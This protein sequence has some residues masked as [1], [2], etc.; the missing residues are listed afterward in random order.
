ME[1]N[2]NIPE[3]LVKMFRNILLSKSHIT[4]RQEISIEEFNRHD[5]IYDEIK[6]R[7]AKDITSHILKEIDKI[8]AVVN[9]NTM[10]FEK[11]MFIFTPKMLIH[12]VE[13]CIQNLTDEQITNIKAGISYAKS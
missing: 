8:E 12:M 1:I 9:N 10:I 3:V 11:E 5:F 7:I 2:N 6:Y 4:S 13:A